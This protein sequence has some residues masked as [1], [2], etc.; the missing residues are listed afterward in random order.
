MKN[1]NKILSLMLA[2]ALFLGLL[3]TS[4]S[5]PFIIE[6]I[7]LLPL[8]FHQPDAS[9]SGSMTSSGTMYSSGTYTA[10][11]QNGNLQV[12]GFLSFDITGIPAGATITSATIGLSDSSV[13][14]GDPFATLGN[15][16]V[17]NVDYGTSLTVSDFNGPKLSTVWSG[18]SPPS[19]VI[20][21][22]SE[23]ANAVASG[24]KNLQF[25]IEFATATDNDGAYERIVFNNPTLLYFYS[26][27]ASKPDL[28]ITNIA[29][30]TS[31]TVVVTIA[32]SGAG[33][34]NGEVGLKIW[35]NGVTKFDGTGTVNLPAGTSA[36]VNFPTLLLPEGSTTVKV[37]IDPSNTV[38][39][40]NETNNERTQT[41]TVAASPTPTPS[42][43]PPQANAGSNKTSKVGQSVSFNGTSSTDSDGTIVSYVWDFGDGSNSSGSVVSHVYSSPGTYTVS[44]TVTDNSGA[45][46]TDTATA[47][48]TEDSTTPTP[49]ATTN[50]PPKAVAG[51]DVKVKVG[52]AVHFDASGSSDPDGTITKYAW[53]FGDDRDSDEKEPL[54]SYATPGVY[55]VTL[56]VTDNN[57]E[58]DRDVIYVTVEQEATS[59]IKGVP[60]FEVPG[61]LG[62]A[63]LVYYYY[64]KRKN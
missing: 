42:N 26:T 19:D 39:E 13:V 21:V 8:L 57:G 28:K 64:R 22:K 17:Y 62:A 16:R 11:D 58:T 6:P 50:K 30:G 32:N 47:I 33:D 34:Y 7:P 48:I 51:N 63:A 27:P 5:A 49:P 25:R 18:N 56:I 38:S 9:L 60:G 1:I 15:L 24:K 54:H 44:L 4:L 46:D 29:K 20:D 43:N 41:L 40:E 12:K 35:F 36:T 53:D 52:E 14:G 23:L 31:D 37:G 61:V 45:T 2:I 10:G 3:T 55:K 59:P